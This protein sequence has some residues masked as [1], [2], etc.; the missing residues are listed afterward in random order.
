MYTAKNHTEGPDKWVVEGELVIDGGALK[1]GDTQ[2]N[3]ALYQGDSDASTVGNLKTDFN[4]LLAKLRASGIMFATVPVV[5]ISVQPEDIEVIIGHVTE[6]LTVAGASS[7]GRDATY[8][9]Y[10]NSTKTTVGASAVD[11]A[12][13]YELTIPTDISATTYYYCV[14]S[15]PDAVAITSDIAKVT[16]TAAIVITGQ[17]EDVE[18]VEG[19]ITEK[20]TVEATIAVEGTLTYQWYSNATDSNQAGTKIDDATGAEFTIPTDLTAVGG[21]AYYYY[22]VVGAQGETSATSDVATVTVTTE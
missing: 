8:Q 11:G 4:N 2:L 14:V 19:A 18:V 15:A 6:K 13:E 1:I 21:P 12:T 5:T 17:P 7:D 10:S 20:L 22:C 16:A 9:W 3:Q